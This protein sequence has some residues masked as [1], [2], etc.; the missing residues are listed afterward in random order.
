MEAYFDL[1]TLW[2]TKCYTF[3]YLYKFKLFYTVQPLINQEQ[4][5]KQGL[6]IRFGHSKPVK[7]SKKLH[8]TDKITGLWKLTHMYADSQDF[9][10]SFNGSDKTKCVKN[11]VKNDK[12]LFF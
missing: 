4:L 1:I 7:F 10:K 11:V 3:I 8:K 12:K 2:N 6:S 9:W 5:K